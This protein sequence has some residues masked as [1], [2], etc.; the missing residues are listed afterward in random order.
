[1]RAL[2]SGYPEPVRRAWLMMVLQACL[3]DSGEMEETI[4]PVF[5]LAGFIAESGEWERFSDEWKAALDQSPKIEYFKMVEASGLRGQ[6]A[7]WCRNEVENKISCLLEI[8]KRN[9]SFRISVAV[10]KSTF[11]LYLR[12]LGFA[13]RSNNIDKPYCLA[14][15]AILLEIPKFQ[16]FH[17]FYFGSKPRPVD[18]VFDEQGEIGIEA[19]GT[20]LI[21]KRL[22]ERLD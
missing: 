7:G 20:W 9:V 10:N 15:Q 16:L 8:I 17:Q 2:V 12:S 19:Q 6:F 13:K 4:N 5:V 11:S 22:A 3:D 1:M 21:L 18:F 14:F